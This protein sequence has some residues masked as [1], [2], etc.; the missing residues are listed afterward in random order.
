M[1]GDLE[2]FTVET[3]L[4]AHVEIHL[5]KLFTVIQWELFV[6]AANQ[7]Q[8]SENARFGGWGGCRGTAAGADVPPNCRSHHAETI[9]LNHFKASAIGVT[10]RLNQLQNAS[11]VSISHRWTDCVAVCPRKSGGEK[12]RGIERRE[13]RKPP[14][15]A[16]I[17]CQCLLVVHSAP[18]DIKLRERMCITLRK[19]ACITDSEVISLVYLRHFNQ[20]FRMKYMAWNLI[21]AVYV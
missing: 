17:I 4:I 8:S 2:I 10:A 14:V 13:I 12:G 7:N 3:H 1:C 11:P 15:M 16:Y 5:T 21:I 19:T 6:L 18:F 9:L 20:R